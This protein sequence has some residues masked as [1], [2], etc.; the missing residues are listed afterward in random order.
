MKRF[1]VLVAVAV[2]FLVATDCQAASHKPV[3][4]AAAKTVG[5]A[6]KVARVAA[7]AP[8]ATLRALRPCRGR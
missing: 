4:A 5:V 6:R 8:C 2:F 7:K 3:R 1:A